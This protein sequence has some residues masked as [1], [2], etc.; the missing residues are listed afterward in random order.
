MFFYYTGA[1]DL[2]Q[3]QTQIQ[4]SLGGFKSST[5]VPNDVLNNLFSDLSSND[6]SAG[7]NQIIGL[8]LKNEMGVSVSDVIIY[9]EPPADSNVKFFVSAVSVPSSG[10]IEQIANN[11]ATPYFGQLLDMTGVMN[12]RTLVNELADGDAIGVWIRRVVEPSS[13]QTC[14]QLYAAYLE[15]GLPSA[16]PPIMPT[17]IILEWS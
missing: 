9:C 10:R 7:E 5:R 11:D 6:L 13:V 16:E 2:E 4:R 12:A 15:D 8:I 3:P 1:P 17:T 14:D